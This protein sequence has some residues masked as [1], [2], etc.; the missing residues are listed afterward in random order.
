MRDGTS[1]ARWPGANEWV[2]VEEMRR[3]GYSEHWEYCAKFVEQ[4]V[5]IKARNIPDNMREE[6]A[7]EIMYR[8][9]KFL[10]FFEFRCAFKT[11][12]N[13][14]A[15]NYIIDVYRKLQNRGPVLF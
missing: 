13:L 12:L 9:A 3:D 14:L 8:V 7:Q 10:P 5:S 1:E 6:I 11:W 4:I 2:V 15:V